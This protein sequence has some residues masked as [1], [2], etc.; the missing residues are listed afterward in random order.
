VLLDQ[1][2]HHVAGE[3]DGECEAHVGWFATVEA[4]GGDKRPAHEPRSDIERLDVVLHRGVD[5]LDR[6][7]GLNNP[8]DG[9]TEGK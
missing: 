6:V 7:R 2:N 1:L 9:L 5:V 8:A 3:R 4:L